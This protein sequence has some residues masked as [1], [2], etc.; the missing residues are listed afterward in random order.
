MDISVIIC[1]HNP[2]DAYLARTLAAL[3]AQ[4]LPTTRWELLVIDNASA[5]PVADRV[6]LNWHPRARCVLEEKLGL[7][8]ARLR[9]VRESREEL[10]VF[11]DDDNVLNPDYLER[12]LEIA[13]SFPFLGSWGGQIEPEF[14]TP[15]PPWCVPYL[16]CLALKSLKR[17]LWGNSI[18]NL[19]AVPFGAGLCVRRQVAEQYASSS[20]Q[21]PMRRS[22]DRKGAQLFS[23]GDTDFALTACDVGLGT[24]VFTRLRLT[25]LIPKERLQFDYIERLVEGAFYSEVLLRS[26]RGEIMTMPRTSWMRA[27]ARSVKSH[28]R[29]SRETRRLKAAEVRG[30]RRGIAAVS[31]RVIATN[32]RATMKTPMLRTAAR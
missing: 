10:L 16:D 1:S 4:T 26:L 31:A 5:E 29:L 30:R 28:L 6:D 32:M 23:A 8:H 15:P 3:R 13:H 27:A 22:L 21:N 14:E 25:H 12:V 20:A 19:E 18:E 17:D 11:V 9:G 24:G 7:T 2:R